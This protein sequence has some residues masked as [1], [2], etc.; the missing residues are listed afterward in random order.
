MELAVGNYLDDGRFCSRRLWSTTGKYPC[1]IATINLRGNPDLPQYEP[2][3][4]VLR[5]DKCPICTLLSG[6]P[7]SMVCVTSSYSHRARLRLFRVWASLPTAIRHQA[8]ASCAALGRVGNSNHMP[9]LRCTTTSRREL[10][11]WVR[12]ALP[13]GNLQQAPITKLDVVHSVHSCRRPES[14]F[15]QPC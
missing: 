14:D 10:L 12:H 1:C 3:A 7:S 13:I 15:L 11:F 6:G 4:S 2:G 9:V 8:S 5:S